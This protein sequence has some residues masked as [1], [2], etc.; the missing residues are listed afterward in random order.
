MDFGKF[1][2]AG[3]QTG[4][5]EDIPPKT[6]NA[7]KN[8]THIFFDYLSI[9]KRDVLDFYKIDVSN[10]FIKETGK[11]HDESEI[12]KEAIAILKNGHDVVF[13]TDSGLPGIADKGMVVTDLIYGQGI[14]VEVIPG[15]TI[16]GVAMAI[17]G[18]PS[19]A[20]ES[21][22]ASFFNYSTERKRKILTRVKDFPCTIIIL[23]HPKEVR[24][25]IQLG[26]EVFGDSRLAAICKNISLPSQEIFRG[27][28]KDLN[29]KNI[30]FKN[31][32]TTI[33]F[34]GN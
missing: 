8:A 2:I 28:L 22:C 32:Y 1:I 9:F 25:N 15:P 19:S 23:C 17:A 4:N 30:H 14:R 31:G 26:L 12:A 16:P 24:E 33:V 11:M 34:Q 7:I 10:K 6:L 13:I 5:P 3:N 21:Y 18:L 20:Q 27:Y 29:D